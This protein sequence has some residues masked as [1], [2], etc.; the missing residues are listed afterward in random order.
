MATTSSY[1][2]LTCYH[3]KTPHVES[4]PFWTT[5]CKSW[6]LPKRKGKQPI[7]WKI[8]PITPIDSPETRAEKLTQASEA[9]EEDLHIAVSGFRVEHEMSNGEVCET[10]V[11]VCRPGGQVLTDL[12][13]SDWIF[14]WTWLEVRGA[15]IMS[16][17]SREENSR[18]CWVDARF[19]KRQHWC[20]IHEERVLEERRVP[21]LR[22]RRLKLPRIHMIIANCRTSILLK[23][24]CDRMAGTKW[25]PLE[26]S[27]CVV[28]SMMR[29]GMISPV[30]LHLPDSFHSRVNSIP[31]FF[32]MFR[33]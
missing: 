14:S 17:F 26:P 1:K 4:E 21:N 3:C 18:F 23:E 11:F 16:G 9:I 5:S 7:D 6:T 22:I 20:W 25:L 28:V 24:L 13:L 15:E 33:M 32:S 12:D 2:P 19:N 31:L 27:V 8:F 10:Y 30:K 29:R